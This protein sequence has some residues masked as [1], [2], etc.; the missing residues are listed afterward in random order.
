ML[1][2][3]KVSGQEDVQKSYVILR[4]D[5]GQDSL[6]KLRW[7]PTHY[8]HWQTGLEQGYWIERM[9]LGTQDSIWILDSVFTSI[10][11][12]DS[13]IMRR[14]TSEWMYMVDSLEDP[15]FQLA[16]GTMF[17]DSLIIN[18]GDTLSIKSAMEAQSELEGRF[19]MAILAAEF[20]YPA[21][22]MSGLA[23]IDSTAEFGYS[24]LYRVHIHG[25]DTM[26]T[27]FNG[28][29]VV[30]CWDS[31]VVRMT[32]SFQVSHGQGG[33][34]TL[35]WLGD[36]STWLNYQ[37]QRSDDG[38][39]YSDLHNLPVISNALNEATPNHFMHFDTVSTIHATYIYRV[40][41]KDAF[42]NLSAWSDTV[43]VVNLPSPLNIQP[44]IDSLPI[45]NNDSVGVY[46]QFPSEE[47]S[48]IHGFE[49]WRSDNAHGEY[50]LLSGE[51]LLSNSTRLYWDIEPNEI[52][53]YKIRVIDTFD[54]VKDSWSGMAQLSDLI[55]PV[56]PYTPVG[57]A[58]GDGKVIIRWQPNPDSDI[59][60][61]R[62]FSS[63]LD[64]AEYTQLTLDIQKDTS[65][66][67]SIDLETLQK[68]T[69]VRIKAI[70]RRGNISEFSEPA[71]VNLP[72]IVPPVPPV[73]V[74]GTSHE[75]VNGIKWIPSSSE[76]VVNYLVKRKELG[77]PN[78][79]VITELAPVANQMTYADTV[80][81]S[82]HAYQ[83]VVVAVDGDDNEGVSN[84]VTLQGPLPVR[85]TVEM[86]DIQQMA[87][88]SGIVFSWDYGVYKGH[89]GFRIYRAIDGHPFV[90]YAVYNMDEAE[91]GYDNVTGVV[92]VGG[93]YYMVDKKVKHTRQYKYMVTA[94]F[95]DGTS[96]PMSEELTI[97]F[98]L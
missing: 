46:W 2:V 65:F 10:V 31:A 27:L 8:S 68:E 56:K 55:P 79:E 62:V 30:E 80:V 95:D 20:S 77:F 50:E 41:G 59:E 78:W 66:V 94:L 42:G 44:A 21:A 6:V 91:G 74:N 67:Y 23:F 9:T 90:Q 85:D 70:D 12:L 19:N 51:N 96:S 47:N 34:V 11:V 83:Y 73:I 61:Y 43:H 26:S 98:N 13:F 88:N 22:T 1:S 53:Y 39:T 3:T 60:G 16:F 36:A 97:V 75:G 54:Y 57:T 24:Y 76:D 33:L 17:A 40:R 32:P 93:Q 7:A 89:V 37:L 84:V 64:T 29:T 14:D 82:V 5:F 18:L 45:H 72:D 86:V 35:G 4:G 87:D 48:K 28:V 38:I 15:Y 69:F 81:N 63:N 25:M 92:S 71:T 52:N 49:V 58:F